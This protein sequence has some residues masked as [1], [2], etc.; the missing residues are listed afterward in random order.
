MMILRFFELQKRLVLLLCAFLMITGAIADGTETDNQKS[1][2][3]AY[4]KILNEELDDQQFNHLDQ[5]INK[6]MKDWAITGATFAMMKNG[7]L[8]YTKG[9]GF[10]DRQNRVRMQPQHRFRIASVSKLITAV[11]IMKLKEWGMLGLDEPVFGPNGILNDSIFSG[12]IR[13]KRIYRI[14]TRHLLTHSAGWDRK[15]KGDP[16]FMTNYIARE[17]GLDRDSLEIENIIQYGLTQKLDFYPGTESSYSNLGYIILGKLIEKVSHS[18]YETF[19]RE[20]I[21]TPLGLHSMQIGKNGIENR[22]TDEVRYYDLKRINDMLMN[23][24][25]DNFIPRPYG[26]TDVKLLS[27]SGGWIANS[28]DLLRFTSAIDGFSSCSDIL[29]SLTIQE[30]TKVANE[31]ILPMGWIGVNETN[32]WWRTGTL[33]GTSALLIRKSNSTIYVFL[34]NSSTEAGNSFPTKA[35]AAIEKGLENMDM[36]PDK[37]LFNILDRKMVAIKKLPP[38]INQQEMFLPPVYAALQYKAIYTTIK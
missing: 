8:V 10:A 13:D 12:A 27:A 37:N 33:A 11:G 38:R 29:D 4:Q 32:D 14:T 17:A 28:I 3:T 22:L 31:D 25:L 18:D 36:I 5:E 1:S 7:K 23:K 24:G 35:Y 21:L 19:V 30:M 6:L 15:K 34:T 9:Y 26:R 2:I 20:H 16:L